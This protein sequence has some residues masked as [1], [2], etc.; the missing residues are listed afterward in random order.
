MGS[1][2]LRNSA[3]TAPGI[4]FDK[5]LT[6]DVQQL[7]EIHDQQKADAAAQNGSGTA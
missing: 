5:F 3:H 7:L 2:A 6:V 1:S 4:A